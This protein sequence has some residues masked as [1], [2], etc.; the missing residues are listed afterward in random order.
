L[1]ALEASKRKVKAY[2]RIQHPFYETSA[3]NI[4][5]EQD[6]IKPVETIGIWW[7]ETLRMLASIEG[8]ALFLLVVLDS[9]S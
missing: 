4:A 3:K 9:R 7:H 2:V 1:L 8:Y 6:D 5:S